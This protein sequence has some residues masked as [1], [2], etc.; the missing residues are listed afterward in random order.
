MK[1]KPPVG[2]GKS[3]SLNHS[4]D[5]FKWLIHSGMKQVTVF[6]NGL[7]NHWLTRF[8]QKHRFIHK[9]NT[10]CVSLEMHSSSAVTL[11]GNI[12]I[13]EIKQNQKT[14]YLKSKSLHISMYF[15]HILLV[16]VLLCTCLWTRVDYDRLPYDLTTCFSLM[17]M[18]ALFGLDITSFFVH[19]KT[20]NILG[21]LTQLHRYNIFCNSIC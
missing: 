16:F 12:L 6:M 18:R 5:S 8:V 3:L 4:F 13:D 10:R 14:V 11:C 1:L 19:I 20:W 9:R 15:L 2:G 21:A 17:E 7:L